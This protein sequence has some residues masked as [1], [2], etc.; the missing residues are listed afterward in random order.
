M[1]SLPGVV[2]S[3]LIFILGV[4]ETAGRLSAAAPTADFRVFPGVVEA[5]PAEVR[6]VSGDLVSMA[7][8]ASLFRTGVEASEASGFLVTSAD[9]RRGVCV[10]RSC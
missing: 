7:C 10:F 8:F 1:Y 5:P 6:V 4:S 2:D 3:F 9:V